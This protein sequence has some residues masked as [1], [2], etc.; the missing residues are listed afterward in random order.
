LAK[1]FGSVDDMNKK[2]ARAQAKY[3]LAKINQSSVA[4]ET[5]VTF[6]AYVEC[7]YLPL[8]EE[9]TRPSACR[10]L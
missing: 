5:A 6:T 7:V 4:P 1:Q 10:G 3:Y 2:E 8:A 9:G